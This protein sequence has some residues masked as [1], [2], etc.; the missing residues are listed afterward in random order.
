MTLT[1]AADP[2]PLRLDDRGAYRVGNTRICL[3]TIVKAYNSG[4]A[5]EQIVQDYPTLELPDVHA[6][7]S[8]YLRHKADVDGYIAGRRTDA[9]RLRTEVEALPQNKELRAKLIARRNQRS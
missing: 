7:I 5:P 2:L 8:Y 9:D 6:V 3:D 1:L 4:M